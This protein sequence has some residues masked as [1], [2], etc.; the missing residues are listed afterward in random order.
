MRPIAKFYTPA[1]ES[2]TG[3]V[4]G[5]TGAGPWTPTN[6]NAGDNLSHLTTITS[7]ANLSALTFTIT[8]KDASGVAL[9]ETITGPNATTVTGTK[10]FSS[11]TSIS[12]SATLG[13]N[14]A[15]VGYAANAVSQ[16]IPM[17]YLANAPAI[18]IAAIVTGTI[19][20]TV[21]YTYRELNVSA[22]PT[23]VVQADDAA[24]FAITA[25]SGKT[26][27]L[28]AQIAFPIWALPLLVNS[29][30]AGATIELDILQA[31]SSS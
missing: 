27:T 18:G 8:G 14:T 21:Q 10:Y 17:S 6:A 31:V 16:P 13:A 23:P 3:Y 28:D 19:N 29:L 30:T 1:A 26:S 24:W 11:I 5:I 25:L 15:D 20:Y 7:A 22:P 2:S 4:T 9:T 12:V